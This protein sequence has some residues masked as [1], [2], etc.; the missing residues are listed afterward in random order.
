MPEETEEVEEVEETEGVE[1][2]LDPPRG[3]GLRFDEIEEMI[4][5]DL[6]FGE[7]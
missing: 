2:Q 7:S 1:E 3:I 6:D 4:D 5:E